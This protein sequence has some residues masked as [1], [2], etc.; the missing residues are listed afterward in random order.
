MLTKLQE[1]G[2]FIDRAEQHHIGTLIHDW[3]KPAYFVDF[4]P[5]E[6]SLDEMKRR[7]EAMLAREIG[8]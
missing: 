8:F 1:A 3:Q 5:I 6:V 2:H 4:S 7:R